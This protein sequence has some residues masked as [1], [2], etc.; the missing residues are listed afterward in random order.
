MEDSDYGDLEE[1]DELE[2]QILLTTEQKENN[3]TVI[4]LTEEEEF[5]STSSISKSVLNS[6]K[7]VH[8]KANS[9][10][11]SFIQK[12][13]FGNV[14]KVPSPK[15]PIS[16]QWQQRSLV[17][18]KSGTNIMSSSLPK[19]DSI[20]IHHVV[21]EEA[22]KIWIY[23]SQIAVRDYQFNICQ[24]AL[25]NNT[26]VALP[27]G[28]GKT[29]IAAV[30]MLNWYRWVPK[31]KIVFVAPTKPLVAQQVEACYKICGIPLADTARLTGQQSAETR[32]LAWNTR[33]VFFMTP[34]TFLND[35]RNGLCDANDIVC[36]VIDEA[37]KAKGS[38]AYAETVKFIRQRQN[39]FRVLAL[40]ATPGSDTDS[41]QAVIDALGIKRIEIR[42]EDSIDIRQ[43]VHK[44]NIEVTPIALTPEICKIQQIFYSVLGKQ[45][46]KVRNFAEGKI[47]D[48]ESLTQ[49]AVLLSQRE[50]MNSI[51]FRSMD[52][53]S[54]GIHRTIF[55]Y[56]IS[57]ARAKELLE[58]HGVRAFYETIKDFEE[59]EGR[60][61][62]KM[63]LEIT[64]SQPWKRMMQEI[65][66]LLSLPEFVSH[67]KIDRA[68]TII[69]NHFSQYNDRKLETRVIVFAQY[70]SSADEIVRMLRRHSPMIRPNVFIGQSLAK[71]GV[72]MTQKEQLSTV[73]DF[74]DGKFNVLVATSIGEEGLDIGDVDLIV[75]FDSSSSPIRMLQRFGRAGRKREG[76]IHVLLTKGKEER[77]YE[78]SQDAYNKMQ[79]LISSGSVFNY[80]D[81]LSPRILPHSIQPE[82]EKKVIDGIQES[83]EDIDLI[84]ALP[85]PVRKG[86]K[87]PKKMHMPEGAITTFM[88]ASDQLRANKRSKKHS[89]KCEEP[90]L[91]FEAGLQTT[92]MEILRFDWQ[93]ND[94][95]LSEQDRYRL[96]NRFRSTHALSNIPDRSVFLSQ[97]TPKLHSGIWPV[98]SLLERYVKTRDA[99]NNIG[100]VGSITRE[101]QKRALV[102]I[103]ND[104]L[105]NSIVKSDSI[106][107]LRITKP[108]ST[109]FV[110][111]FKKSQCKRKST[112]KFN[113]EDSDQ[114]EYSFPSVSDSVL[115]SHS[116][117]DSPESLASENFAELKS[118]KRRIIDI[119]E[120]DEIDLP[121]I[122]QAVA[123]A[124]QR[125]GNKRRLAKKISIDEESD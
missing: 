78:I 20:P 74:I 15:K 14:S 85:K 12:D 76:H 13:L 100:L 103:E 35:L 96:N 105:S 7:I 43:Y 11:N 83:V 2:Q 54:K 95:L 123:E 51:A 90:E 64:G 67:P 38:Y 48:C 82:C 19:Q 41:V 5:I 87:E 44:R 107:P 47:R 99:M 68:T 63:K 17:R 117:E 25:L 55:A 91:P 88:K 16:F 89:E 46:S 110:P 37:H 84:P 72:G 111:K 109:S 27:T 59:N 4:N 23:P 81:D 108:L 49:Y 116:F 28:L 86:K 122:A 121:D 75:S 9:G 114:S 18:A 34:Q 53:A 60:K 101:D 42:T 66:I 79:K 94:A 58:I 1:D 115:S 3:P 61:P 29:F 31:G 24:K 33:R 77:K 6:S 65:N 10:S 30:I 50:F 119:S 26:L 120:E 69:L 80:R 70:R 102:E 21:D 125:D 124:L 57:L 106:V 104:Y 71:S 62:S 8:S 92:T 113:T 32:K 112:S 73:K 98:G 93:L 97:S 36:Y 40:S 39:A 118:N 22:A 56:M 52:A 45:L